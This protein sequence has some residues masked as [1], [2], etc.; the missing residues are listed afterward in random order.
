MT[1]AV[2]LQLERPLDFVELS[3]SLRDSYDRLLERAA[4]VEREL[5]RSH[6]SLK[7]VLEAAPA[8]VVTADP[9]G[10][11]VGANPAAARIL[12]IAAD[13]LVGRPLRDVRDAAGAALLHGEEGEREVAL[14]GGRSAVVHR[15]RSAVRDPE[16]RFLGT[17][18]V[19]ED[20]TEQRRLE[21]RMKH[22]ET[23]A[24]LGEMSATLAHEVRNPLH[25]IEGFASLL[26]RALPDDEVSARPRSYARNVVRGVR[27][28]NAI[29]ENLL[30]FARTRAA[31][32]AQR[33]LAAIARRASEIAARGVDGG[34]RARVEIEAKG[35]TAAN[36]DEV[37]VLQAV[38]NL[39][40]NALE[41]SPEGARVR[42][43]ILRAPS[44]AVI[45]VSDEGA[46]VPAELRSRIFSPFF[47][48]KTRGTGLGL[49]VVARAA[50]VHGGRVELEP[51]A[52]G[53]CFALHL[54]Q[55]TSQ[56]E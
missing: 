30:E 7:A 28:L 38:R 17:V 4:R 51:T 2:A 39:V 32:F 27:E 45:R 29:V 54:P 46:G 56:E 25:G 15:R 22:R 1:D 10:T 8:G 12:G 37:L 35:R 3:K 6:A 42:V 23:L 52:R 11:I 26:L 40:A 49:A 9:T 24:A 41:A 5:A 21:E 14:A 34:P 19:L 13:A 50:S 16:G 48:T 53:A 44:E 31:S 18:D 43:E 47:T 55:P 33:D 20:R 36:V